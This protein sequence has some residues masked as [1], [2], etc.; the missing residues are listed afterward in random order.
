MNLVNQRC[1]IQQD[2]KNVINKTCVS[3]FF[4]IPYSLTILILY[5]FISVAPH[6][7]R[8]TLADIKV[9]AGNMFEFDVKVTG[10]PPPTKEWSFKGNVLVKNENMSIY[11]QDYST[12]L[13][14]IDAKRSDDGIYFLVAKNM[15]GMDKAQVKVTVIGIE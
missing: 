6:I 5:Y 8:N 3:V 7:D 14:V 2:L 9:R 4:Y 13:K 1:H 12:K 10:E 15:H 11:N